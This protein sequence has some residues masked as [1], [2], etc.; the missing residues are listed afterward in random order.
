[1][2][3]IALFLLLLFAT[4]YVVPT[5]QSFGNNTAINI[6]DVDE[7][8]TGDKG[9][10]EE[11][12]EKKYFSLFSHQNE[13]FSRIIGTAIHLAEQIPASPCM[14]KLTPPPNFC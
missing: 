2:K 14:E 11:S 7:E 8:K 6:F 12:K 10:T 9:K 5:L 13:A 3:K 4:V 1:M